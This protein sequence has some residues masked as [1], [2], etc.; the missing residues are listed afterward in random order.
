MVKEKQWGNEM[1]DGRSKSK[2]RR[3][4]PEG[5]GPLSI[6]APLLT[7]IIVAVTISEVIPKNSHGGAGLLGVGVLMLGTAIV[8]F[9]A[10]WTLSL[11]RVRKG[12]PASK[13]QQVSTPS[14]SEWQDD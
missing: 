1:A 5:I 8:V 10:I 6:G 3:F 13:G 9:V 12:I 11:D 14:K 7:A 2:R 4:P